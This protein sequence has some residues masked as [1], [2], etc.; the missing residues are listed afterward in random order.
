MEFRDRPGSR[1]GPV[2]CAL[3]KKPT[4]KPGA[5]GS[6]TCVCGSFIR[7]VGTAPI[8]G[9]V[10]QVA[11]ST[12]DGR[13]QR[14]VRQQ[15]PSTASRQKAFILCPAL[16]DSMKC[17]QQAAHAPSL[18][19]RHLKPCKGPMGEPEAVENRSPKQAFGTCV[20]GA[21]TPTGF[22]ALARACW[23]LSPVHPS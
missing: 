1:S 7:G 19:E 18:R 20:G 16:A 13:F 4:A 6:A 8:L 9:P 21:P 23:R 22:H 5:T 2:V 10:G 3:L 17:Y 14:R 15:R 11:E 12:G